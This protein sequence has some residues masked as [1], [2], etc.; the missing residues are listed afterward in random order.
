MNGSSLMRSD[1]QDG[2]AAVIRIASWTMMAAI[3]VFLINNILTL[4][5]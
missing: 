2:R 3:A 1:D 4:G 5:W